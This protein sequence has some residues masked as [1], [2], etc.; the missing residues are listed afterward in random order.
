MSSSTRLVQLQKLHCQ[1]FQKVYSPPGQ[2]TGFR[3][4]SAPLKAD[5]LIRYYPYEPISIR[6]VNE[7]LAPMNLEVYDQN[8]VVRLEKLKKLKER[9][10]GAPVKGKTP[11]GLFQ[12]FLFIFFIF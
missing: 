4:L 8:R 9:G 5:A 10:K 11:G 12:V 7:A 3:M 6:K 2:R 1:L